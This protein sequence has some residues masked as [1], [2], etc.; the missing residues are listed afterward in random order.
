MKLRAVTDNKEKKQA[1]YLHWC[2]GCKGSHYIGVE[3]A[4]S[5]GA[6]WTFNGD[7]EKPTFSPSVKHRM[8]KNLDRCCHYF[9]K[10]GKIEYCSDCT[11]ELAGKTVDLP[12]FPERD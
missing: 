3:Q 1:G 10:N 7:V 8:G 4:L 9:I 11:H 2:P 5:N 6:Q 12:D